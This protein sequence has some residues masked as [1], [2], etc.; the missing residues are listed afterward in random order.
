MKS[1]FFKF[2]LICLLVCKNSFANQFTFESS[3]IDVSE[4]G[5]YIYATEGKALSA[6]KDIEIDAKN[7]EYSKKL[8]TLKAEYGT[9][10]IKSDEIKIDFNE[11]EF[12]ET[13]S[14]FL[15]TGNVKIYD[16]NKEIVI[17]TESIF[18]DQKTSLLKS[19]SKSVLT[20][21]FKN[22]FTTEKFNYN[23]N[24]NI[25]K[26]ENAN[27][28]DLENNNFEIESAFIN[29][30]SNRLI[31]KDV[32]INLNNKSFNPDNEP[33]LKGKSISSDDNFVEIDKGVFTTCK[34]NDNCPPWKLTAEKIT[35]DKR[36][37][38]IKYKNAWLNLYDK[39][40]V[41]F[42]K[43][44]HPDP[45][46]KR[47]SGFLIPSFQT[48]KSS[49]FFNVPYFH[50]ISDNKDLTFTPR[51][52]AANKILLQTEYRQVNEGSTQIADFS[53]FKETDK[54]SKN[55]FFYELNKKIN[56]LNFEEG[57]IDFKFQKSSNDTYLRANK[58]KSPIL[59]DYV[60]GSK[61]HLE[62]SINLDLY[63][64]DFSLKS[65]LTIY[66]D[67]NKEHSD[68]YEFIL[69]RIDLTKKL[70]NKTK[71]NGNFLFNTFNYIRNYE[72]N[73]FEKININEL[74]FN[75]NPKI[76][77]QGFYNN[78]DFK[79]KNINS[80][81]QNSPS[82][83]DENYYLS[84]ILQLNSSLPLIKETDKLRKIIKP[85]IS[86]KLSPEHANDRS[87]VYTPIS[88]GSMY[89]LD[90]LSSEE[91]IEG[92]SSLVYGNDFTIFDKNKSREVLEIKLANNLR[93]KENRDL[94]TTNQIGEKTSN[95]FSEITYSPN[96]IFTTEYSA[97]VKNNLDDISNESFTTKISLNNFV[98]SFEYLNQNNHE[99][100]ESYLINKTEYSLNNSN[101][102]MFSTRKNKKTDLTEY[103]NFMYQYKNDCLAASIEYNKDYYSDRDI[104]PEETIFLKLT[105]IPFGETR[106]VIPGY[107]D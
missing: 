42:P 52:Y 31:G 10:H 6:D 76:T 40:V 19:T 94:P 26:I 80:D 3:K 53:F 11:I 32:M 91:T 95:F 14:I 54:N 89:S 8:K 93:L 75:S 105:I 90:R 62:N 30:I 88:I 102:L 12:D 39:P 61:D 51:L 67:L 29:T 104:K 74:V 55:H 34:K 17:M 73:I 97:E 36:N 101:S 2:L 23:I 64:E 1:N 59:N 27:F 57:N 77:K 82:F 7:F 5:D 46:V 87:K 15:A 83:K 49:S 41:Y 107:S 103:Y 99:D 81:T 70:E 86:L 18:F 84:G 50:V 45:T 66:E 35:H 65:H 16:L 71:L 79:F 43:F 96:E 24:E 47:R 60:E 78:Y 21:R 13:N 25:L 33:R 69:P 100:K 106:T 20:D 28:K 72:T 9:A 92:G 58:L 68:R 56:Y 37:K 38:V 48:T 4:G 98:T 44:F 85:R 63:S 22:I